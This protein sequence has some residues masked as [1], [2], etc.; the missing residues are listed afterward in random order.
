MPKAKPTPVD[1]ITE[2]YMRVAIGKNALNPPC[3]KK[4][5]KMSSHKRIVE[6]LY[7]GR[8]KY[9]RSTEGYR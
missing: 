1:R 4:P 9:L 5:K 3:T 8:N 7:S 6:I 2:G